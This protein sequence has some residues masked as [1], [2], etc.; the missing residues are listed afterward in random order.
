MYLTC[1]KCGHLSFERI[2][3]KMWMRLFRKS[4]RFQ[5][6]ECRYVRVFLFGQPQRTKLPT[7]NQPLKSNYFVLDED[8]TY[9]PTTLEELRTW[10]TSGRLH[11]EHKVAIDTPDSWQKASTMPSLGLTWLVY[12]AGSDET[13]L[14]HPDG[15]REL[16]KEGLIPTQSMVKDIESGIT[17]SLSDM[18]ET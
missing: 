3:R 8:I 17:R 9:G 6:Y 4:R 12:A 13:C 16:Y 1:P 10:A 15:V 5:C 2:R 18:I 14:L 11:G 7:P